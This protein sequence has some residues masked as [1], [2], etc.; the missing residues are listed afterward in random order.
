MPA[1]AQEAYDW[2]RRDGAFERLAP[3]WQDVR[4]VDRSGDIETPGSRVTLS[5]P[6]GPIRTKWVAEHRG[7]VSGREFHDVQVQGPF[8]TWN[9]HHRF[10]PES[11][12]T[13]RLEDEIEYALP[14]VGGLANGYVRSE[15]ERLFTYRHEVTSQDLAAHGEYKGRPPM[16]ILL[17]GASGLV[18]TELSSF[19]T[20]GGHETN[21][22]RHGR[23]WDPETGRLDEGAVEN[24]D[25]IVHLA[26]ENIAGGRWSEARK[27]RIRSSR[28]KGTKLL[29]KTIAR[30]SSKPSVLVSASAIGYYGD[31]GEEMLTEMSAPGEGFLAEVCRDWEDATSAAHDAGV[32]VVNLRIG[33]VLSPKGGALSKMLTPFRMGVGGVI[34]DG[35]QYMSWVALD[36]LVGLIHHSLMNDDTF[37]PING[38]APNPVTN[39]TF[40]KTLGKV[41]SR[42]TLLPLPAF[43]AKLAMGE[44]A[45]ELLLA[46]ARVSTR[47][48][49]DFRYPELE[50]ALRH[51]LGRKA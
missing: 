4:V 36:D 14:L 49:Y 10:S 1:S 28:I 27:A 35:D 43:A 24:V 3:P 11:E 37:G 2:H 41:L 51:V 6:A 25:A 47:S 46:S 42:P 26:G 32:R 9:H 33:I 50:P 18:G 15:L 19:L 39:R 16:K 7:A 45:D 31:R 48:S 23:D 12:T 29:C 40:T 22:L 13:S 38:V 8:K 20:T 21:A 44:M 17:T 5:V 34:G 30:A